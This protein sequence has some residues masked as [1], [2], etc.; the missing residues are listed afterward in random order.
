MK[1]MIV[2]TIG[3]MLLSAAMARAFEVGA[4][5]RRLDA[6]GGVLVF[7]AAGQDRTARIAPE[8]K[9][10]DAEGKEL[11]GGLKSDKLAPG[12]AVTLSVERVDNRPVVRAIRLGGGAGQAAAPGPMRGAGARAGKAAP[13]QPPLPPLDTSKLVALTDLGK[14][15]EYLGFTGG[16]YPDGANQRPAAHERAG[17]ALAA[18]IRP[19]D[20]T[21]K[22]AADGKIVLLA[23]GFSNTVQSYEGFMAEASQDKTLNPR[24]VLVNGAHGGRSAFM[25]QN[26][27][28]HATGE[29]Y[30]KTWVPEHLAAAGV[31]AAQVQAIWLKETDAT[32]NPAQ[33][34]MMGLPGTYETPLHMG[35][36][37]GARTLQGE[38]EKIVRIMPGFYPNLKLVYV[39]SRSYGGWALREGNREP[40]S[41]ETG[42]SVKWLIEKQFQGD[43]ALNFDPA[44]G[45]AVAPWLSWGPYLWA[46]GERKRGDGFS[47]TTEDYREN[48][49]MHYSPQG[50]R[51]I[52]K[53]MLDFFK[54]DT[55]AKTWFLR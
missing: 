3:L 37:R 30:W 38:L 34:K 26:P 15:G 23:I 39:S 6:A 51:K 28:D 31:S 27:D 13:S 53:L 14:A 44:K 45:K 40:W 41:Y 2:L 18:Q 36:P 47:F 50:Q 5:I 35:F 8:A 11:A 24:L 29:H 33:M 49:R 25:I 43:A 19:L 22:A 42:F 46:N 55:T 52:G 10:L 20:A 17:L 16:L 4:Q 1:R 32:L 21:G 9:V 54:A 7:N 48:D 12:A